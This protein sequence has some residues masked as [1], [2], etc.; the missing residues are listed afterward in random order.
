MSKKTICRAGTLLAA[1]VLTVNLGT[2]AQREVLADSSQWKSYSLSE[3]EREDFLY[4]DYDIETE[5]GNSMKITLKPTEI[6]KAEELYAESDEDT[7]S[8]ETDFSDPREDSDS[9]DEESE[10]GNE[11]SEDEDDE[12]EGD[13]EYSDDE[14]DTYEAFSRDEEPEEEPETSSVTVN[15]KEETAAL[16]DGVIAAESFFAVEEVDD[17]GAVDSGA[18]SGFAPQAARPATRTSAR[19]S[20]IIFFMIFS[21]FQTRKAAPFPAIPLSR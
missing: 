16:T 6:P 17:A 18:T 8:E 3:S 12:S 13:S 2:V 14:S 19:T 1:G 5:D 15:E 7:E 9:S 4:G 10:D 20:A 21:P 11:E